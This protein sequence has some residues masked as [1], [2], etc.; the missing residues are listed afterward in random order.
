M[1]Q[2]FQK[3]AI[4]EGVT[5]RKDGSMTL[6]FVTQEITKSEKVDLMEFYQSFGW[7]LFSA[8]KFQESEIPTEVA[9]QKTGKSVSERLRAVIFIRW[10]Q[11]G[12]KGDFE[13]YYKQRMERYINQE[14]EELK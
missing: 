5:P 13:A 1:A 11:L 7:L 4:L 3:E 9:K 12:A 8:N 2:T 10:K 14:K 6:R